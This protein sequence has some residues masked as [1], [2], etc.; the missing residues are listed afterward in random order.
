LQLF[1]AGLCFFEGLF[2]SFHLS[3]KSALSSSWVWMAAILHLL[4]CGVFNSIVKPK[5]HYCFSP[6]FP[7][8][9]FCTH[10][11]HKS[12]GEI[13]CFW[14]FNTNSMLSSSCCRFIITLSKQMHF[15]FCSQIRHSENLDTAMVALYQGRQLVQLEN[16]SRTTL[17]G[18]GQCQ[19]RGRQGRSRQYNTHV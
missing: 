17:G 9:H 13:F 12:N 11:W 1:Q 3:A 4:L 15:F 10:K 5:L 2:I 18:S 19:F 14:N 6:I 7:F 8:L 16:K